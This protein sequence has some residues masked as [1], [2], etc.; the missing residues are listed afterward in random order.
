MIHRFSTSLRGR[1][2]VVAGK[3]VSLDF[4]R[5]VRAP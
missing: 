2:M 3:T 4:N 1:S 5:R